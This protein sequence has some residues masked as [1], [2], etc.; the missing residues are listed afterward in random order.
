MGPT[1]RQSAT[2]SDGRTVSFVEYG[3]PAGTPVLH[4]HGGL[5]SASD[6]APLHEVA[7]RLGVR[8]L[9]YDRPGIAGST[10]APGRTTAD[11]AV[12]AAAV[13]D[14]L[15]VDEVRVTGWSMG[16]QYA[17]GT[18]AG[19]GPRVAAA[20]VVAGCLPLDDPTTHA[21]L[22]D[23][24]QRFTTMAE[25][26]RL[27]LEKVALLWGGLAR[28]SPRGWAAA[29][30]HGQG[31]ADRALVEQYADQLASAAHDMS[32]QRDGIVEE[33][34][35]WARPWGFAPA[36]V[37]VRVDVWQGDDDHLVPPAWAGRLAGDLPQ[38]RLNLVEGAGHFLLLDHAEQIL[39]ALLEDD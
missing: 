29:T 34:L 21:E 20:A 11:A 14:H 37:Q 25:H 35:A 19:L 3:D 39:T 7:Q 17:L 33:Y 5:L 30:A 27:S 23:M 18:C 24:D 32:V 38:A 12:D 8:L 1:P 2:T 36:D 22:N 13:L 26:H 31:P 4:H 15:G 16:G 10:P 28:F 6:V 9:S